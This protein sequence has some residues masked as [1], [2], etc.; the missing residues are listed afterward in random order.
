MD[1][2]GLVRWKD[3]EIDTVMGEADGQA[4]FG[5]LKFFA[6]EQKLLLFVIESG[7]LFDAGENGFQC[8]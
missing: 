2:F 8:V 7:K 6:F 4:L 5:V 1:R 3:V